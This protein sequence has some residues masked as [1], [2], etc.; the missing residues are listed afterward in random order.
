LLGLDELEAGPEAQQRVRREL[1][2]AFSRLEGVHV[3]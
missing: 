2:E 3:V 1:A